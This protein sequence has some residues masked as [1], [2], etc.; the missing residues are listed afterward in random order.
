MIIMVICSR[1]ITIIAMMKES[2]QA[3]MKSHHDLMRSQR[4]KKPMF[5]SPVNLLQ[6]FAPELPQSLFL[7]NHL[8]AFPRELPQMDIRRHPLSPNLKTRYQDGRTLIFQIYVLPVL[9][10]DG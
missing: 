1:V 5:P 9:T 6:P 10:M 3:L 2:N 8:K 4:V 7:K